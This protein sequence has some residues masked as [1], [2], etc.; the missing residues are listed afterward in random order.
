M[1]Q[2]SIRLAVIALAAVLLAAWISSIAVPGR[3]TGSHCVR[4]ALVLR[5]A[6]PDMHDEN[7]LA[8]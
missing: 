6:L 3:A 5:V 4:E 7:A 1:N 8:L 2:K